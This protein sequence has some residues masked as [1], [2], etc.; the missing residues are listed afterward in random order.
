MSDQ[1]IQIPEL[2]LSLE[3]IEPEMFL[4]LQPMLATMDV[5]LVTGSMIYPE[6]SGSYEVTPTVYEQYLATRECVLANDI[7][8]HKIPYYETSNLSGGYTA[9]IGG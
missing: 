5:T 1:I 6:Y 7:T 2:S 9:I 8:V 3:S 4:E